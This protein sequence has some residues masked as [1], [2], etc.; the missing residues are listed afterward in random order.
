MPNT[1][2]KRSA[3]SMDLNHPVAVPRSAFTGMLLEQISDSFEPASK[4]GLILDV[5]SPVFPKNPAKSAC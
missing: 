3:K 1:E 4:L 5:L 2:V